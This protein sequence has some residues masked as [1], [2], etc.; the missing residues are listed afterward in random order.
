[1]KKFILSIFKN[2]KVVFSS[3]IV[4][5]LFFPLTVLA[6]PSHDSCTYKAYD[7]CKKAGQECGDSCLKVKE[8]YVAWTSCQDGCYEKT[9]NCND[10]TYERCMKGD[11]ALPESSKPSPEDLPK[12]EASRITPSEPWKPIKFGDPKKI[13]DWIISNG[14]DLNIEKI[15]TGAQLERTPNITQEDKEAA[16][17][18]GAKN[19]FYL[20]M[21]FSET[22]LIKLP[23][24]S[25]FIKIDKA[26]LWD[27]P[28]GSTIKAID[29]SVKLFSGDGSVIIIT[30]GSEAILP[31]TG[32]MNILNGTVELEGQHDAST[33]FIDLFIIGTHYWITH[34]PGK[35]TI[36]G[37]Y[38]GQVEVKTKD[39]KTAKVSP[40][41]DKPGVVVVSQ[42]LSPVKL[43]IVGGVLAAVVVGTILILKRKFAPKGLSKRSK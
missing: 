37:V 5:I 27:F 19:K 16:K 25:E 35:E 8:D 7:E 40:S 4:A 33:E 18:A 9:K 41:G 15:E 2:Q 14:L 36:V 13:N 23:G 1:M 31:E 34:E 17:K 3:I 24:S 32:P 39:G 29:E 43:S 42:K 11:G 6:Q 30:P 10:E 12:E 20:G 21:S 22:G 38:E 26:R 28:S